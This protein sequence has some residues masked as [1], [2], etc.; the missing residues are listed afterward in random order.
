MPVDYVYVRRVY[1]GPGRFASCIAPTAIAWVTP[2]PTHLWGEPGLVFE[3]IYVDYLV[4]LASQKL[5]KDTLYK[6][7]QVHLEEHDAIGARPDFWGV[8]RHTR[9]HYY[10]NYTVRSTF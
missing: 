8:R 7:M 6:R 5:K 9:D 10:L 2:L 1:V 3:G 4:S